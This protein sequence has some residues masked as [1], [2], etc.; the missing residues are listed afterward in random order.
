[1]KPLMYYYHRHVILLYS[2]KGNQTK[3]QIRVNYT[4]LVH[5]IHAYTYGIMQLSE[6][7]LAQAS[8]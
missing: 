1:M 3:L 4:S 6:G 2:T 5:K 7:F 8:P